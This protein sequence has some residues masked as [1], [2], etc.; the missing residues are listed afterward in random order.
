MVRDLLRQDKKSS[1]SFVGFW[2]GGREG[3]GCI[4]GYGCGGTSDGASGGRWAISNFYCIL[5]HGGHL[6]GSLIGYRDMC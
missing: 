1:S 4:Y 3:G 6:Q 5:I 2:G